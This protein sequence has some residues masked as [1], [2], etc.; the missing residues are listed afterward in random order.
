MGSLLTGSLTE[1]LGATYMATQPQT[2]PEL[3]R[4]ARY[5]PTLKYMLSHGMP[6]TREAWIS[7]NYLGH[8]PDPWTDEH[9]AEVPEPLQLPEHKR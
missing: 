2:D 5:S 1:A 3:L 7:M 6:V 8:P 4:A 9:E